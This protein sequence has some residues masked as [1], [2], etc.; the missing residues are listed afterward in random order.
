MKWDNKAPHRPLLLDA[1]EVSSLRTNKRHLSPFQTECISRKWL[2]RNVSCRRRSS[3]CDANSMPTLR[4]NSQ[5]RSSPLQETCRIPGF[6]YPGTGDPN[7]DHYNGFVL[8]SDKRK[9]KHSPT[10]PAC[11]GRQRRPRWVRPYR[12]TLKISQLKPTTQP[13][14]RLDEGMGYKYTRSRED[15]IRVI[16]AYSIA[17]SN[18]KDLRFRMMVIAQLQIPGGNPH[19]PQEPL[20]QKKRGPAS[21]ETAQTPGFPAVAR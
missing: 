2:T 19:R 13:R 4:T 21:A 3:R 5:N 9:E 7:P 17:K 20:H 14:V 16:F 8:E 11:Q 12:L 10:G 1:L 6:H 15:D 18:G